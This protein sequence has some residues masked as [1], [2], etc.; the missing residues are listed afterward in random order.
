MNVPE[1]STNK[2]DY[3]MK[4]ITA[5]IFNESVSQNSLCIVRLSDNYCA[6]STPQIL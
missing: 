1:R 3:P 5:K 2:Y 4:K 6:K